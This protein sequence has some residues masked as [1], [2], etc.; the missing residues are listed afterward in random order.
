MAARDLRERRRSRAE[1]DDGGSKAEG[2]PVGPSGGAIAS[3]AIGPV[4]GAG[5]AV[6]EEEDDRPEHQSAERDQHDQQDG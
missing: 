5:R 1:G 6:R 4:A 3:P 2:V